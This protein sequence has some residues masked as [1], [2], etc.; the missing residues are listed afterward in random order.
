M[1]KFD[2]ATRSRI[3]SSI[4]SEDTLPEKMVFREL[5]KRGIHFQ[6]HHKKTLGSP[7]IALPSKKIAIFIDGD[8]W[9]GFRYPAWKK[10]LKSKF[11]RDKIER[12]RR[13]DKLYHQRLRNQ[14]WKVKRIWEH[15]LKKDFPGTIKKI[16]FFMDLFID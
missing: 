8:F 16:I 1:D 14:G 2:K 15:Q 12:N 6:R 13:R 7:D 9:H 3:M 10:R 4:R 5:R 11:W